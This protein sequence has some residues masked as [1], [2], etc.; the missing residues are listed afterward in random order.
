M[1]RLNYRSGPIIMSM[2]RGKLSQVSLW[3]IFDITILSI[4]LSYY[5][6]IKCFA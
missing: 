6:L 4:Y 5:L 1:G 3:Q 2:H